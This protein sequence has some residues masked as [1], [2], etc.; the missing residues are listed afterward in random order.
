MR[1][2]SILLAVPLLLATAV[3]LPRHAPAEARSVRWDRI[4]GADPSRMSDEQR[5]R[6][7]KI[8]HR[9][10]CYFGCSRSIAR[11]L[12]KSPPSRTAQRLGGYVVR[13]VL[14][15]RSDDYISDGIRQRGLSAHPL[16]LA[17]IDLSQAQCLGPAKAPVT[18]VEYA[19]F[20]CPFCRVIS[21]ILHKLVDDMRPNVRL[22]FKHFPVRGHKHALPTS[23]AALA[24][25]RQGR[26]WQMHDA[27]YATAPRFSEES[28]RA[29][30]RKAKVP[31][32]ARWERDRQ[33][34]A[35]KTL[36]KTDKLEGLRN[37]VRGTP[38]IFVNRKEY[39][40]RKDERELRD[41]F[42]EELDLVKG[43]P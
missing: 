7:A 23:L 33:D 16:E 9:E 28:I 3:G 14:Q 34:S 37:G 12:E 6:A 21:P 40:G 2:A 26:F 20:E 35:F 1:R 24:A 41:R 10:F 36:I 25:H 31:D 19:D 39:L 13:Q 42:E 32:M 43:R 38:T 17:K 11:C 30:A 15:D 8:L 5:A 22:C 27:L 29:S 18:V 4:I